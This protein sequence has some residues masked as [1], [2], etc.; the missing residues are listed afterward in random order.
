MIPTPAKLTSA[1]THPHYR[2]VLAALNAYFADES[3][4]RQATPERQIEATDKMAQIVAL[5]GGEPVN[6][7]PDVM[8]AFRN[9]PGVFT[10][11]DHMVTWR[12]IPL[13]CRAASLWTLA[14]QELT[15]WLRKQEAAMLTGSLVGSNVFVTLAAMANIRWVLYGKASAADVAREGFGDPAFQDGVHQWGLPRLTVAAFD[16]GGLPRFDRPRPKHIAW[17]ALPAARWLY[18]NFTGSIPPAFAG[19]PLFALCADGDTVTVPGAND[20]YPETPHDLGPIGNWPGTSTDHVWARRKIRS[21]T[22]D[23]DIGHLLVPAD[24]ESV[25]LALRPAK[26]T[27]NREN[28]WFKITEAPGKTVVMCKGTTAAEV[29]GRASRL[30]SDVTVE[31]VTK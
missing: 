5:T 13:A 3:T 26:Y 15:P 14:K 25:P 31:V 2:Q 18:D 7:R 10:N 29:T 11:H 8:R 21:L 28:G 6:I 23:W 16:A 24:D 17:L 19:L 4:W 27:M 30:T 20:A 22:A 1:T 9:G 12:W